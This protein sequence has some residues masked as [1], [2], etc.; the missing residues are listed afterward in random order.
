[1]KNNPW[2]RKFLVVGGVL[3]RLFVVPALLAAPASEALAQSRVCEVDADCNDE[4]ECTDDFCVQGDG[5]FCINEPAE[6]PPPQCIGCCAIGCPQA[7]GGRG[8]ESCCSNNKTECSQHEQEFVQGGACA[9]GPFSMCLPPVAFTC[10]ASPLPPASCR[11]MTRPN[12]HRLNINDWS[13]KY[14]R[15]DRLEWGWR[16]GESTVL[17]DFGNPTTD[18]SYGLCLYDGNDNLIFA[19]SIE[20]GSQWQ[21]QK[22]GFVYRNRALDEFGLR[23]IALRSRGPAVGRATIRVVAAGRIQTLGNA[24]PNGNFPDLMG[25]PIA[26][27][28]NPVRMQMINSL[29]ACWEGNYQTR[30]RRNQVV[31]PRVSRFRAKND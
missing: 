13:G 2:S 21:A 1:M 30:I 22:F 14:D 3:L 7:T 10:P 11:Q 5:N 20:A 31:N 28:P 25:F 15:K 6:S 17:A 27:N 29:G 23:R 24:N 18:T 26:A 8:S 16:R 4:D 12:R 9:D 19:S